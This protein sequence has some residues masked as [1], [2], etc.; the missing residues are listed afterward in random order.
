MADGGPSFIVDY[1]L[2]IAYTGCVILVLSGYL[3]CAAISF[4]RPQCLIGWSILW[5]PRL[6][7]VSRCATVTEPVLATD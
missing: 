7:K 1:P 4:Y 2:R 5:Y 6:A 3:L